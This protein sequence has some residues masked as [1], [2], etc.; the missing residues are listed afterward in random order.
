MKYLTD[1]A[2]HLICD[3]YSIENLHKMADDLDI[4]RCWFHDGKFPH[5]DIPKRRINEIEAKCE[6]IKSEDI[7]R[8]IKKTMPL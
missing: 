5:Y 3:P 1:G 2:R 6:I 4:K 8:I 7:I